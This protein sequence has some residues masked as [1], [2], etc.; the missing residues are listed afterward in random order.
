MMYNTALDLRSMIDASRM[1]AASAQVREETRG[2]HFRQDFPK[3]RDDYGLFNTFLHRG[4]D[5]KPVI[6][7]KPVVFKYKSLEDCQK[8]RKP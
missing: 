8:Y 5:G 7:K 1:I 6:E 4:A 3:Q 2:A